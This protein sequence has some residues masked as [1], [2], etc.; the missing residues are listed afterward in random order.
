MVV[1]ESITKS[2]VIIGGLYHKYWRES[3]TKSLIIIV[4]IVIVK[5]AGTSDVLLLLKTGSDHIPEWRRGS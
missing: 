1:R 5:G 4:S 3:I 2:L